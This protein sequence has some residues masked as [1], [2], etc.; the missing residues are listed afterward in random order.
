VKQGAVISTRY[1]QV[2]VLRTI[3][4]LLGAEHINLN[5]AFQ[6]PMSD[7]FDEHASGKWT[8]IAEKST[9]LATTMLAQAEGA[10]DVRFAPGP[11]IKPRHTA[12]Y[13][14]R[15]TAG[16]DFSQADQVP[17]EKFNRVL[18]KGLMGSKPYPVVRGQDSK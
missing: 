14:A 11:M 10:S 2:N 7:V 18:W 16:F 13:W 6:R 5:T 3:E 17:P 1:S 9:V 12:A 4:D 8:F 15:V